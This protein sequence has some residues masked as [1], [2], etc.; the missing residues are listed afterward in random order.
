M[1]GEE[2]KQIKLGPDGLP[3][4]WPQWCRD[5]S[6]KMERVES[7]ADRWDPSLGPAWVQ[8]ILDQLIKVGLPTL[9]KT[10]WRE[11]GPRI[12]GRMVGHELNLT[13]VLPAQLAVAEQALGG[14]KAAIENKLEGE[15]LR[16]FRCSC[17][18]AA[19]E[20]RKFAEVF[21]AIRERKD[22]L[23]KGVMETA[24]QRPNHEAKEFFKGVS[25]AQE[26]PTYNAEGGLTAANSSFP[27]YMWLVLNWKAV[28][29]FKTVPELHRW[30]VVWLGP[31]IVPDLESFK[32]MCRRHKIKLAPPGRPKKKR[33]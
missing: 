12:I 9:E 18:E 5:F 15:K 8:N 22:K 33:T 28:A 27:V 24:G 30:V 1:N 3:L 17:K 26:R 11:P 32:R 10:T 23:I 4:S 29:R 7:L 13:G 19:R 6:A 20:A 25:E 31:A 16:E 2:T 21:V 14:L